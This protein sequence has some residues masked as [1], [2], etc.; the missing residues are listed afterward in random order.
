MTL[1]ADSVT[2]ILLCV[3][4][5]FGVEM[6]SMATYAWDRQW[7]AHSKYRLSAHR[8]GKFDDAPT[9]TLITTLSPT[10]TFRQMTRQIRAQCGTQDLDA[11]NIDHEAKNR[12]NI[13]L[14][15]NFDSGI[16]KGVTNIS[17]TL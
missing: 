17:D 11:D 4:R 15:V 5:D 8:G 14:Q 7:L 16:S 1:C 13:P 9:S 3:G 6:D 12:L 2:I 10:R